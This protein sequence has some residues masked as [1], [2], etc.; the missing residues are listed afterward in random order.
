M[1]ISS[2]PERNPWLRHGPSPDSGQLFLRLHLVQIPVSDPDRSLQFYRDQLG[3]QVVIDTTLPTGERWIVVIPPDGSAALAL[4]KFPEDSPAHQRVGGWTGVTFITEDISAQYEVWS[5]RS[6]PFGHPP[7]DPPWGDGRARFAPFRDPDGNGFVLIEFDEMTRALEAERRAV[8]EKTEAE[9]RAAYDVAIAKEVQTR[10]LPQRMPPLGTLTYAGICIPARGVGGDYYDYLDLGSG[11]LG[12]VV[13]DVAGK[14]MAAALLMAN[15]QANLR[16]QYAVA[17]DDLE[18]LLKSVNRLFYETTSDTSYATLF[19]AEYQ[20]DTGRLR[21][22]NCGHLPPL[23][24]HRDGTIDRLTSTCTVLGIFNDWPFAM[25]DVQLAPG[26]SLVLYTDGVTE[27]QSDE[28][29]EF[30]EERL[31]SLMREH[32]SLS[33]PA[34]LQAIVN[35]V[36]KFSG[37][38]QEDDITLVVARRQ[39]SAG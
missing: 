28:G 12:L 27:A 37:R 5:R 29:E 17:L 2:Q 21:Y 8:A 3:F 16:S 7:F 15:L 38:E 39:S 33:A 10:L 18:G 36:Q 25:A 4:A 26:D 23:L 35:A 32:A 11:R 1:G 13:G 6:I 24:L 19:F 31:A 14:G 9:R 22:A 20:D 30:G 34:L